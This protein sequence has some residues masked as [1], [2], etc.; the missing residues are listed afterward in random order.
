MGYKGEDKSGMLA[1]VGAAL[2]NFTKD[3]DAAVKQT[4]AWLDARIQHDEAESRHKTAK[5]AADERLETAIAKEAVAEEK[6]ARS[7]EE[8]AMVA[9][10]E[11]AVAI[12]ENDVAEREFNVKQRE[13][14]VTAREEALATEFVGR[15]AAL[16]VAE[17]GK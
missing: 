5:A 16:V 3:P 4:K 7:A 6:L 10:R 14:A 13:E 2:I 17:V 15:L 1:E 9:G 12:R 11:Q 8:A